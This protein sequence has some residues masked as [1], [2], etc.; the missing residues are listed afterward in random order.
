MA[1]VVATMPQAGASQVFIC[2][3]DAQKLHLAIN[4]LDRFPRSKNTIFDLKQ[5]VLKLIYQ[6]KVLIAHRL[7]S[8][9]IAIELES[10]YLIFHLNFAD[11]RHY[12][13][14]WCHIIKNAFDALSQFHFQNR[15]RFR[16]ETSLY[17]TYNWTR[18]EVA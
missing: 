10:S 13:L 2:S 18:V 12:D 14:T 16:N 3:A 9:L 5:P 15:Y 6:P 8:R 17:L 4:R 1:R 11:Q 7:G